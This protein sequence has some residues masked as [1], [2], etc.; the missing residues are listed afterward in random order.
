MTHDS[1]TDRARVFLVK[2]L[3]EVERE[4]LRCSGVQGP[5]LKALTAALQPAP[6][7]P[8]EGEAALFGL[9]I[10][11]VSE[12]L[13]LTHDTPYRAERQR[14]R[15]AIVALGRLAITPAPPKS[16]QV[17]GEVERLAIDQND[18]MRQ[19]LAHVGNLV[20]D[21]ARAMRVDQA[22]D[23]GSWPHLAG[24]I[25]KLIAHVTTSPRPLVAGEDALRDRL[26]EVDRII[27]ANIKENAEPHRVLWKGEW[28]EG[29]AAE[30]LHTTLRAV[31][32]AI[33]R[34]L[35]PEGAR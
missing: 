10:E 31:Q 15:D 25:Q 14:A 28:I 11:A 23:D 4:H 2:H 22:N 27:D 29:P 3:T 9:L 24:R 34:A 5:V 33:R 16:E 18:A 35:H 21:L 1:V 13:G 12:Y 8:G 7:M 32:R 20:S 26:A 17:G 6:E 30:M 19:E